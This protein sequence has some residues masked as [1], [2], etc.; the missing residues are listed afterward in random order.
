M[1]IYA[2]VI[3]FLIYKVYK[4]DKDKLEKKF[5]LPAKFVKLI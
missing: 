4:T 5:I 2:Y 1:T 3:G